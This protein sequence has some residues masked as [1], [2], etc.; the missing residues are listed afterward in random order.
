[1]KAIKNMN[2]EERDLLEE[3]LIK[4]RIKEIN[5]HSEEPYIILTNDEI[6]FL[7]GIQ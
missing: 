7:E 4:Y 3:C 2:T 6:I 5:I 1:M